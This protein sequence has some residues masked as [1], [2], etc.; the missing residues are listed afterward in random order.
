M[1]ANGVMGLFYNFAE[2]VMRL[3]G[4]NLLWVAF[5]IPI[6]YL[7]LNLILV[8]DISQLFMVAVTIVVLI[9]F[10]FFPATTAMFAITR[11]WVMKE[12]DI[13]IIRSYLKYYKENYVR[14]MVGGLI[15]TVVWVA[16]VVDY[17]FFFGLKRAAF[18][19]T[20]LFFL[21]IV[22]LI[23]LVFLVA[24]TWNFISYTVHIHDRLLKS[25]KDTLIITI[26]NPFI[27]ISIFGLTGLVIY[28]SFTAIA[29]LIPFFM[30]VLIALISFTGFYMIYVKVASINE[31]HRSV[32]SWRK[33]LTIEQKK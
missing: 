8:E 21:L 13:P 14:S 25:L 5:N 7:G 33:I 32:R 10:I 12:T 23:A 30:G 26:G 27:S 6:V 11:K 17:Y 18:S 20:F 24:F 16:Y 28:L 15:L 1:R 19:S 3:V 4:T 22:F 29:F 2:W 9:P 31:N